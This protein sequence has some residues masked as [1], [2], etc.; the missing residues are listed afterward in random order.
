MA[1][2]CESCSNAL[3]EALSCGLPAVY[4]NDGGN[5][6]LT[7]FGGL[8]FADM[9]GC[10]HAIDRMASDYTTFQR[11]VWVQ[12]IDE[13]ADRYVALCRQVLGGDGGKP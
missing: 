4:L 10:L 9:E 13:I 2:E 8:P 5:A 3:I 11:G 7:G 6:E 12:S 1:S